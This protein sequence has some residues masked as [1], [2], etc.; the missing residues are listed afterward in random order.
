MDREQTPSAANFRAKPGYERA[1]AGMG[2][3]F[4]EIRVHGDIIRGYDIYLG[5]YL[6]R[7]VVWW[8]VGGCGV[9]QHV[10]VW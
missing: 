8:A 5:R 1:E 3:G 6:P 2:L 10:R 9:V 7:Y 4:Q